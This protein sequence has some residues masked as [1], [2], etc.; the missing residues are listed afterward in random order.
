[1]VS[2]APELDVVR[3]QSVQELPEAKPNNITNLDMM[4]VA[5][6]G[7]LLTAWGTRQREEQL[8]RIYRHDYNW[9]V[10][11]AFAGIMKLIASTPLNII[12]PDNLS[13]DTEKYYKQAYKALG[14]ADEPKERS[15]VAYWTEL[16]KQVDFGRGWQSFVMK[17]VDYLRQDGG[18]YWEII[19][20]GS[21][22]KAPTGPATGIA[23]LDSLRC[24]PSGDPEFPVYYV[25]R[26]SK[27][28]RMHRTRV[29]QLIDMPDGD[30]RQPGYGLCALSRA[31]SIVT[32]EVLMGR[33]V[34][35][36]LDDLPPPGIV[37]AG[38]LTEKERNGSLTRF[39]QEQNSDEP[40]PWG[41]QLWMF[42]ADVSLAPKIETVSFQIAPEKFDFQIYTELDI[43]SLALAI[44]VDVQD[45]WQLTSG[46][47]GSGSQS[48]I[49]NQKSRGKTVGT[50]RSSIEAAV[51]SILPEGYS[52]SFDN[53][54]AQEDQENATTAKM[55]SDAVNA[56]GP[57]ISDDEA[58][59]ILADTVEQY[60][61]Q[62]KDKSGKVVELEKPP[63]PEGVLPNGLPNTAPNGQPAPN[64]GAG[65]PNGAKR[66]DAAPVVGRREHA[67]PVEHSNK[68]FQATRLNFE[69]E[70]AD[71]IEAAKSGDMPKTR[72]RIVARA[73]LRRHGFDAYR[74]G[75]KVGG[76]DTLELDD[77][78]QV[79]F[80]GWL[81][82]Q[83]EYINGVVER[84]YVQERNENADASAHMWAN[85]SLQDVYYLGV[86]S[87]NR[88][89]MYEFDGKDG[90]ESCS[91]CIRLKAQRHRMKD[92]TRR[93]LRPGVD[94]QNFKCGGW[95]C[96]H[97][98][99][100]TN[101]PAYGRF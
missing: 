12:A 62:L 70:W 16:I 2:P 13:A 26:K 3:K 94:T 93:K 39:R 4:Y 57:R 43:N 82:R 89:G 67:D 64:G 22:N 74:D 80:A 59:R 77:D 61:K 1:M 37:I 79:D 7:P 90:I 41:R 84:V 91:T 14:K 63:M 54:D 66:P 75:L 23:H 6:R 72:F 5:E 69:I 51:T 25:D 60:G 76:V 100:R 32:R 29:V 95:L 83:N 34:E 38:G 87:A 33:Y 24:I 101:Q 81:S 97:I 36:N 96:N 58:R 31:V 27:I 9:M 20:P 56:V 19:A 35:T 73:L 53:K 55:W 98:L 8:R 30:E 11:G 45:L 68:Q 78:E 50:L 65:N 40:A 28:H 21:P 47:L 52:A 86:N 92:W 15:D 44:G 17:G 42:A 71:L 85:K 18:W 88:N 48:E 10:Q 99:V 49:L 46:S